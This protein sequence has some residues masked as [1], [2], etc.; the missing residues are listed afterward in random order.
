VRP[1]R[2]DSERLSVVRRVA[3]F[4]AINETRPSPD[5]DFAVRQD[6]PFLDAAISARQQSTG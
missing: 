5:L 3:R 6:D 2:F 1:L 4:A